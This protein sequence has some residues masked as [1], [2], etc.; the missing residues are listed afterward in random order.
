MQSEKDAREASPIRL[1][2]YQ[3]PEQIQIS[4]DCKE[5]TDPH[6]AEPPYS[7]FS[8]AQKRWI[9]FI[10]AFAGMFFP[11]S[12]FIY[13]PAIISIAINL[14]TTVELINLTIT[15]YMIVSG[16]FPTIIGNAAD[17][18]G[19]RPVY[20]LVMLIYFFANVGLAQQKS[21]PALLVLLM[22]Q[23]AGNSGKSTSQFLVYIKLTVTLGTISLAYGVISDIASP[24][25][26]GLYVGLVL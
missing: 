8:V 14:H 11:M 21:F 22:L 18:L 1:A 4:T 12:S 26:R 7:V 24:A 5:E 2:T 13:Y 17:S 6:D 16:I 10:V 19:R 3:D 20:A 9:T 15:S 25:E 23:S